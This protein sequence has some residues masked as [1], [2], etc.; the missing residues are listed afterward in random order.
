MELY[1]FLPA[2]FAAIRPPGTPISRSAVQHRRDAFSSTGIRCLCAL[3]N[4]SA[5]P[6][7]SEPGAKKQGPPRF[8]PRTAGAVKN[9]GHGKWRRDERRRAWGKF[10]AAEVGGSE[11]A[12]THVLAKLW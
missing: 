11:L 3:R 9:A 10:D 1:T 7:Q 6:H 8:A 5:G 12:Q 4:W 2:L